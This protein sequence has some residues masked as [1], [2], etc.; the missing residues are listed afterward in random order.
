M[1]YPRFA[2]YRAVCLLLISLCLGSSRL[3]AQLESGGAGLEGL[4]TDQGRRGVAGA[5]VKIRNLETGYERLVK[6]DGA[7]RFAAAAMPVGICEVAVSAPGFALTRYAGLLLLVGETEKLGLSLQVVSATQMEIVSAEQPSV[8]TGPAAGTI[9]EPRSVSDLP[10]RGR[11]FPEFVQLVPAIM[12][13]QDRDGLVISGQ[14]SINSNVAIDGLDFNNPLLGNQQGGNE[15]VFYFPQTAIREFQVVRSGAGAEVGRTGAG[16]VNVVTKSG[17]NAWHGEALYFHR[18]EKLTSRDAFGRSLDH[19]QNQFGGSVGGSLVRNRAFLFAGAEQNFLRVP[20]FVRFQPQPEEVTLPPDLIRL[21]GEQRGTNNPTAVFVRSDYHFR[22]G[23]SLNLQYA[24]SR[25]RGENFEFESM[26]LHSAVTTNYARKVKSHGVKGGMTSVLRSGTINALRAQF[27]MDQS[28]DVPNLRS[29]LI[30]ITGFGMIGG[31]SSRP[32]LYQFTR[33][34]VSDN[35]GDNAGS[36]QWRLGFDWNRNE[37]QQRR[38]TNIQGRYDFRTLADY[39]AGRISRYRQTFGSFADA[40]LLFRGAQKELAF[41][42]QDKIRLRENLALTAGLRWEGQWNPRPP[43]PNPLILQTARIPNDLGQWQPRLGLAW[44]PGSKPQ[45]IV[46][47]SGGVYNA[48]TPGTLFQRVFT[49]NGLTTTEVDSRWDP[50]ILTLAQIPHAL[51]A[52][53]PDIRVS[54]P[55]VFGFTD[56][57]R[58]PQSVQAA[59]TFEQRIAT[60]LVV[61]TGYLHS[62]TSHLQRRVDRNLFPPATDPTG[63]PIF[64]L[65]RPN[66]AIGRLSVNESTA[67]SRYD[68]L[69]LTAQRRLARGL[70]F[71]ASYTLA[72]NADDDS[73]ERNF[74]GERTL[75]PFDFSLER[76]YSKQDIRHNFN[77]SG[78][79]ELPWG[80]SLGG[81]FIARSGLPY[82]PVVG[83]DIQNDANDNND[84][85]IVNGRVARRNSF[86]QPGFLSLDLRLLK[87][88]P[89][90]DRFRME[91]NAESFNVL[92]S[93]NRNFG[94]DGDSV[95][96]APGAPVATAG[97]PLFAPSTARFGGPRQLQ[98]GLR[99][100][101]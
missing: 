86:R 4:V 11:N 50:R 49:D 43:R 31:N 27:A 67:H 12:Q 21:E 33:S 8:A 45:T 17:G 23:H 53:P 44:N 82:T 5:T 88:L 1:P 29:P 93:S 71:Q 26:Q 38:E 42:A 89:V 98:L 80:F 56:D 18:N 76:S 95:Y 48:R 20:Y 6:T 87:R 100:I 84:R 25:L 69:I 57:F 64:P 70:Q 2:L 77:L 94:V 97:Q 63:L 47:L 52:L 35:L 81:I 19:L 16:F 13:E 22:A 91:L 9:I 66:P 62:S 79:A 90:G 39:L 74:S 60:D 34:Q 32:R 10:I 65:G 14:R 85:A 59:A 37:L 73:N 30:N 28:D 99:L 68:A 3:A 55:W 7:G 41:F 78:L 40:D 54:P 61:S 51:A 58:N 24:L 96:G 36:H 101:F 46:R 92:R 75:N 83:F 72:R 15:A